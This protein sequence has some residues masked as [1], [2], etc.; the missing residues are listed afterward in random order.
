MS[1]MPVWFDVDKC[2]IG[3]RWAA[4]ATGVC[5]RSR[6]PLAASRSA[7]SRA[8]DRGHRRSGRGGL[9]RARRRLGPPHRDRARPVARQARPVIEAHAD[10]LALHRGDRR[11]QADETGAR[12]RGRNGAL[13][14]ILRR[15]RRQGDG[16]DD[17]HSSTA[18]PC[19]RW[20][21]EGRY[22]PH[23]P[24]ELSDADRRP[25]GR[26]RAGGRQRL[27]GEARGRGLRHDAR[28][29]ELAR[30]RAFPKARSTSCRVSAKRRARRSTTH[31]G[32]RY[33][34]FTGR[35][36]VGAV[37]QAAAARNVGGDAG[38]RRQVAA[39]RVRRRGL[40]RALPF[41]V[42]AGVQNAGQTCS[43]GSRV[44]VERSRYAEVANSWRALRSVRA[45]RRRWTSTSGR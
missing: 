18:T 24:V 4:P 34:S 41:V 37:I 44:L 33:L 21:A 7:R 2:F 14:G 13:Y 10:D 1:S 43:A 8:A 31:P 36:G 20:R 29:A 39:G 19:Y 26:R 3:G 27:R 23:R 15:R 22:R 17:C 40:G 28:L 11:R 42:N 6:I 32:M 45:A 30:R 12:R 9:V 38:T 16:R 25:L 35:V 5:C